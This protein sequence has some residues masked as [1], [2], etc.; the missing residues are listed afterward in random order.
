MQ[1]E[2]LPT[3][4]SSDGY[5]SWVVIR[6]VDCDLDLITVGTKQWGIVFGMHCDVHDSLILIE[7][8]T[9]ENY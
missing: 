1:I 3:I 5:T 9:H 7:I 4:K 6:K 2:N 8:A